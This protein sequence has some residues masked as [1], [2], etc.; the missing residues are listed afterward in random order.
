ML[1]LR[2][3][4]N[5]NGKYILQRKSW[6]GTWHADVT[7]LSNSPKYSHIYFTYGEKSDEFSSLDE[8]SAH[9]SRYYE[10]CNIQKNRNEIN[11]VIWTF[12]EKKEDG[13]SYKEYLEW[14]KE[15]H[16]ETEISAE[17]EKPKVKPSILYF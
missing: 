8:L 3:V 5:N 16:A 1:K 15:R 7:V 11:K 4:Q 14:L 10:N 17:I 2:I 13:E 12:G 6:F 9:V